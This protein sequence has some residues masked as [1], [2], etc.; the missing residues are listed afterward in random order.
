MNWPCEKAQIT[1][2][3]AH[4]GGNMAQAARL[5]GITEKKLLIKKK[6]RLK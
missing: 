1:A 4:P 6:H 3:I 2:S 5:L